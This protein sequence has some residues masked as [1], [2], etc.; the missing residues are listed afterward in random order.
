MIKRVIQIQWPILITVLLGC[1]PP[2]SSV[3]YPMWEIGRVN[4]YILTHSITS[5]LHPPYPIFKIIPI[6]LIIAIFRYGNQ[7]RQL[8]SIYVTISYFMF[9]FCQSI[10]IT[11]IYGFG[12]CLTSLLLS[13]WIAGF[14]LYETSHPRNDFSLRKQPIWKYW[15]FIPALLA[16]WEPV[17][18]G[19]GL[20][21]FQISYWIT[22]SAG[23]SFCMMT[24]LY[25]AILI[26]FFPTVNRSILQITSLVGFGYALGNLYIAFFFN[27]H[28]WWV[29]ILHIP[30]LILSITGLT[31][32]VGNPITWLNSHLAWKL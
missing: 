7:A 25:L 2:F 6:I 4:A 23:L 32:W 24:P 17:N 5:A 9:A 13:I 16:F 3:G 30:L 22:S 29:G 18:P 31:L 15:V 10:S 11:I 8:F 20:P 12:I 28:Y 14:W 26:T 1:I 27:V 21:D 19:S